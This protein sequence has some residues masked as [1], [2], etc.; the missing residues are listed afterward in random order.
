MGTREEMLAMLR[1]MMMT[2]LRESRSP[3]GPVDF[4]LILMVITLIESRMV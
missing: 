1:M 3:L 4:D 2:H